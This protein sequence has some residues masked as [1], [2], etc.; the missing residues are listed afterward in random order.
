MMS[1]TN[2]WWMCFWESQE[3]APSQIILDPDAHRHAALRQAGMALLSLLRPRLLPA[4]DIVYGDHLLWARLRSSN[5]Y[6]SAG[7]PE[8]M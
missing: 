2:C 5:I 4:A 7:S 1:P 6:A 8:E 3:E